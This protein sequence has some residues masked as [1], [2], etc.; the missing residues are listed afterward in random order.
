MVFVEVGSPYILMGVQT[1]KQYFL[2][3]V[4]GKFSCLCSAIIALTPRGAPQSIFGI[5]TWL[6]L[7]WIVHFKKKKMI[8]LEI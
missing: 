8:V 4:Y 3:G 5:R 6:F 1:V 2:A 7:H